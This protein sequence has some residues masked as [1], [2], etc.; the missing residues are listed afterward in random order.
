MDDLPITNGH[1]FTKIPSWFAETAASMASIDPPIAGWFRTKKLRGHR[2]HI[3]CMQSGPEFFGKHPFTLDLSRNPIFSVV[4][5]KQ[6]P[7]S[8]YKHHIALM[9]FPVLVL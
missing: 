9:N 5:N 4:V 1:F 3:V 6:K 2:Y 7:L 8:N